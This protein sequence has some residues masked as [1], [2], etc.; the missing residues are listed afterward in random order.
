MNTAR[1]LDTGTKPTSPTPRPT[2]AV[3]VLDAFLGEGDSE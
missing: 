2:N 3:R 1:K